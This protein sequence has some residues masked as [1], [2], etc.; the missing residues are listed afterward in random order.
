M[1]WSDGGKGSEGGGMRSKVSLLTKLFLHPQVIFCGALTKLQ[2]IKNS[3]T[4]NIYICGIF[5]EMDSHIRA[6]DFSQTALHHSVF[7]PSRELH[8]T[9][10]RKGQIV[11]TAYGLGREHLDV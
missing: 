4:L 5:T 8:Y 6:V 3:F 10:Y 1:E 9:D 11:A 7:V 2:C